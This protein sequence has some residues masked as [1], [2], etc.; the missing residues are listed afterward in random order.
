MF[1]YP[2]KV[3]PLEGAGDNNVF[4][5]FVNDFKAL[6]I[7]SMERRSH[8]NRPACFSVRTGS[9]ESAQSRQFSWGQ[10]FC[11]AQYRASHTSMPI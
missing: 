8:I 1:F 5:R 9:R 11:Y 10:R 3:R 2:R 7:W 6:Y 4:L